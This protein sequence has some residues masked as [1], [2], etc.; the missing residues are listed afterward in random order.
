MTQSRAVGGSRVRSPAAQVRIFRDGRFRGGGTLVGRNWALT[1]GHILRD[2]AEHSLRF[3]VI[4]DSDDQ[5]GDLNF[6]VIDRIVFHP[7][8]PDVAM[9]HFAEPVPSGTWIPQLAQE[10]PKR[11][12]E[13]NVFAWGPDGQVLR[14]LLG[15]VID[16]IAT[17]NSA[18]V[19]AQDDRFA[20]AFPEGLEPMAT[21]LASLLDAGDS[22]S[23][24]FNS[25][26]TFV[27][28]H[29]WRISYRHVGPRG[30]FFG[31]ETIASMEHPVWQYRDWIL[32]V[33]S[34]EGPSNP[35]PK[36]EPGRLLLDEDVSGDLPMT[37][38]PQVDVCDPGEASC[39]APDPAWALGNLTGAGNYRGTT[40]AV[41]AQAV[42]NTCSF[43][44]TGYAGGAIGRLALGPSGAPGTA[45][46]QVMVWCKTS[47]VFATGAPAQ[48]ALRVSFTNDDHVEVPIGYGWWDVTPDQV[49]TGTGQTPVDISLLMTC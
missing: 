46:R 29:S 44:G 23:G 5:N 18:L 26:G 8:T 40:L 24:L 3:G 35:Q 10:V 28:F 16:P 6:R 4:D 48:P 1:A 13:G 11:Y 32:R 49:G 36:D 30:T 34:G 33:M 25:M 7:Q 37:L 45:P 41:C 21:N 20:S 19:R 15:V 39:T 47:D 14:R 38:P 12:S 42:G 31:G 22:G 9:V 43:D 2:Q 17:E 27:G